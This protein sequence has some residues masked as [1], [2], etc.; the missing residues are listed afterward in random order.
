MHFCDSNHEVTRMQQEKKQQ[1][2]RA[3]MK[4]QNTRDS[5][6]SK[7]MTVMV[8]MWYWKCVEW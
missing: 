5:R 4:L 6:F 7:L 3:F 2:Q 8:P 1:H